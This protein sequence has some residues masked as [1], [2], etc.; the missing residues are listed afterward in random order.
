MI[1]NLTISYEQDKNISV[2]LST[3][4]ACD[5]LPYNLAVVFAK[6]IRD[7]G[8]NAEMV[9][10]NLNSELESDKDRKG[11]NDGTDKARQKEHTGADT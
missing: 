8:T 3:D 1:S 2:I 10:E 6:V 7:S 9:I 4:T 11:N 5:N